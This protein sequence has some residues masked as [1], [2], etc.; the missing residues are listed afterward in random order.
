VTQAADERKLASGTAEGV[1]NNDVS[2]AKASRYTIKPCWCRLF[3]LDVLG[4]DM[5][6]S[7]NFQ[8]S[9]GI[10]IRKYLRWQP[11]LWGLAC[12]WGAMKDQ[13]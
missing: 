4:D 10:W 5:L 7:W 3:F 8:K 13:L 11:R 2:F 6:F 1:K 12:D 9:N